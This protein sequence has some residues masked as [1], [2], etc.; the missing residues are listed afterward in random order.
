[1]SQPP[2]PVP[3]WELPDTVLFHLLQYV[4]PPTHRATVL[5]HSW[6][7]LCRAAHSTL[8]CGK[9]GGVWEILL[10]QDYGVL[11]DNNKNNGHEKSPRRSC[12]RLRRSVQ[13]RV[14]RAHRT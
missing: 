14:Q 2:H 7:L 1:M 10:R 5:C 11:D 12:K 6:A 3:L 9:E 4:A 8:L 13:Q